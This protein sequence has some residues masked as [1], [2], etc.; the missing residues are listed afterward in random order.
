MESAVFDKHER[1]KA[2]PPALVVYILYRRLI[3]HGLRP[4][5]LWLQDKLVRR[6]RGYSIPELSR[7]AP[8]LYV[9]GQ[10]T[11]GGLEEMRDLGITAVIN[12]REEADDRARKVALDHY[13]WLPTTDDA[14]PAQEDLARGVAFI[15]EQVSAG[16][17]VYIH[18]ASGVGRAPTM[19]AAYLVHRG[20][21]P[22]EA[23]ASIRRGRPFVRPTPPQLEAVRALARRANARSDEGGANSAPASW[24]ERRGL[25]LV[26]SASEEAPDDP[27]APDDT[28]SLESRPRRAYERIAADPNLTGALTDDDARILLDWARDEVERL[29]GAT[30][31]M[32]EAR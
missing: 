18:C 12:M 24:S 14:A 8:N 13:L 27:S 19:A 26:H 10:H 31:R 22:Q 25:E 7:V 1:L 16:R 5:C 2:F 20:A 23:W 6:T 9:G 4:T 3:E 15:E 32:D 21:T 11:A 29:V 30:D 17:G 28:S